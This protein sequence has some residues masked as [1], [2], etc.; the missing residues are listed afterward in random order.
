MGAGTS[1]R[2]H[3]RPFARGEA[4]LA[5]DEAEPG[6]DPLGLRALLRLDEQVHVPVLKRRLPLPRLVRVMWLGE[7]ARPVT[8]EREARIAALARVVY[9]SDHASRRGNCLGRSLVLYRYLSEAGAD[10]YLVV[11]MRG[12]E[13]AVRGHAWVTVRGVPV[14]EPPHSLEGL[15][16]VVSFRGD[17]S[18]PGSHGLSAVPGAAP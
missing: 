10:P 18:R 12:G 9:R 4:G 2:W 1:I 14:E 13:A 17:G 11:G 3:A 5:V 15:T 16:Q 8:P 6:E 7:R